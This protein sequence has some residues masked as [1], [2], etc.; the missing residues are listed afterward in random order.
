[1]KPGA[2]NQEFVRDVLG[3]SADAEFRAHLL[4]ATI[5]AARRRRRR[6]NARRAAVVMVTVLAV[7]FGVWRFA[8]QDRALTPSEPA[9]CEI[10]QTRPLPP[11]AVVHTEPLLPAQIAT[12]TAFASIVTTTPGSG[13][14]R[15]INDEELLALVA[16][17]PAVLVRI[18]PHAQEL[19]FVDR[20]DEYRLPLN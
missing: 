17:R 14:V 9:G 2:N 11:A 6:R 12:T 19:I 5:G 15:Y 10:V 1:M 7:T 4:A 8:R 16:P 3:E 20:L 13:R 18:G